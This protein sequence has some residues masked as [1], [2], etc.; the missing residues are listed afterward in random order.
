VE[1]DDPATLAEM[2]AVFDAY[3][4]AF[5]SNDI[6]AL[7]GYFLD[8]PTTIRYGV[9]DMQ[10]GMG[11]L[12]AHRRQAPTVG[13]GRELRDTVITTYGTDLAVASTLFFRDRDAGKTGRQMQTWIR[14]KA[15]WRIV[16]AHVSV[17]GDPA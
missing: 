1:I 13:L 4:H 11:E 14:T 16:A 7:N 17:I 15:G 8:A 12:R 10:L 6:E 3:E 5:V 9:A 2:R